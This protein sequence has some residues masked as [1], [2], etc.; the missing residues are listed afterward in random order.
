MKSLTLLRTSA[1]I[2]LVAAALL[3]LAAAA[4]EGPDKEAIARGKLTF[5]V[6]CSNC[7]GDRAEGDGELA[8]LLSVQPA[9]L[10]RITERYDGE[11]PADWLARK[12]DGRDQVRGHG[13]QEMPVWGLTF[14]DRNRPSDQEA[15]VR[16]KIDQLVAFLR[17]IQKTPP[18]KAR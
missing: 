13:M 6:Y 16:V 11:F 2:G 4:A 18:Q 3:S 15:E 14:R 7:H 8:S 1:L 5:R 17:S 9:D 12:I 10:T